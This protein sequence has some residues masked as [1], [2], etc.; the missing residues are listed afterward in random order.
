MRLSEITPIK[1]K[2]PE[3]LRVDALKHAAD[4]ASAQLKVEKERQRLGRARRGLIQI[5]Q[6]SVTRDQ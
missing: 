3:Q 1:P 5:R 2:T 6:A 4:Q